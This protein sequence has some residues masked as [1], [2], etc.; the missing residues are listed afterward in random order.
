MPSAT[1]SVS[2]ADAEPRS[3]ML[4]LGLRHHRIGLLETGWVAEGCKG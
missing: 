1:A 2:T 3:M 4:S